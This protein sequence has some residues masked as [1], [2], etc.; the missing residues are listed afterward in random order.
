MR[1]P[2]AELTHGAADNVADLLDE[3]G[4]EFDHELGGVRAGLINALHRVAPGADRAPIPLHIKSEF[5][6]DGYT[7]YGVSV[8]GGRPSVWFLTQARAE[9][10]LALMLA[11]E[12]IA[13]LR[14][15]G[16]NV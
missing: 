9:G 14:K 10:L 1:T 7:Y 4:G 16:A 5:W 6:T 3:L 13:T 15:G 12:H 11:V 2:Y 8:D